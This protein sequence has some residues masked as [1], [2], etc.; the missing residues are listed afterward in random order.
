[1]LVR[2]HGQVAGFV[3]ATR[4]RLA[5]QLDERDPEDIDRRRVQVVCEWALLVRKLADREAEALPRDRQR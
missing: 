3:G 1:M 4:Y 2:Y 5:P